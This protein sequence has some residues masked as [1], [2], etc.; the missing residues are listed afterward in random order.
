MR[1]AV[2]RADRKMRR[3]K[4]DFYKSHKRYR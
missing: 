2:E 1:E 3:Q 4:N